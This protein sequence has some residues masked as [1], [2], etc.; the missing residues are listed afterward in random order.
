MAEKNTA[1]AAPVN[2]GWRADQTSDGGGG[3]LFRLATAAE[4][5]G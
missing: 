4:F 3:K 1:A 2:F 5:G